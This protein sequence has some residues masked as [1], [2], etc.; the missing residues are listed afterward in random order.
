MIKIAKYV[1]RVATPDWNIAEDVIDFHDL[2]FIFKGE[3][4]YT[5]NGKP[6]KVTAGTLLHIP[7]G[8][9]RSA[10]TFPDRPMHSFAL[11][12]ATDDTRLFGLPVLQH[13]GLDEEL[14]SLYQQFDRVWLSRGELFRIKTKAYLN[15]ILCRAN[16]LK[17]NSKLTDMRVERCK[18]Y[19]LTNYCKNIGVR[20]LAE[21]VGLNEVYFGALFKKTTGQSI[22]QYI[23]SIRINKAKDLLTDGNSVTD[24]SRICGFDSVFYFSNVFKRITGKSPMQYKK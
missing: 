4:V 19:I 1:Q 10:Y 21:M 13:V 9:L 5:I 2:T 22:N 7:P 15:L 23:N 11:N 17:N 3:A 18:E 12:L 20:D 8:S 6:H 14:I 16:E 24:T